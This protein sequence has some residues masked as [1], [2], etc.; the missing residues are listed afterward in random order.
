MLTWL[1]LNWNPSQPS[2]QLEKK[3]SSRWAD[4][5]HVGQ[6]K[7]INKQLKVAFSIRNSICEA[8][9]QVKR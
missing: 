7:K 9:P 3:V 5:K 8:R 4:K 2:L 6:I 1:G